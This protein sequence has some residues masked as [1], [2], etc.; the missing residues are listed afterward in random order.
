VSQRNAAAVTP[1]VRCSLQSRGEVKKN[2]K[3][4]NAAAARQRFFLFLFFNT[5]KGGRLVAVPV[6]HQPAPSPFFLLL[7]VLFLS[8]VALLTKD[9]T[10]SR[11]RRQEKKKKEEKKQEC[12]SAEVWVAQKPEVHLQ[13]CLSRLGD[14]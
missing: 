12:N 14:I 2:K 8:C 1:P 7:P 13:L 11:N 5:V 4:C 3:G 6:V 10:T 9:D